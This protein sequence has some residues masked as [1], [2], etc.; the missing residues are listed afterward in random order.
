MSL[1]VEHREVI[2]EAAH[3]MLLERAA[4][5]TLDT[6]DPLTQLSE[7]DAV[8]CDPECSW[9]LANSLLKVSESWEAAMSTSP[10]D[11]AQLRL[12]HSVSLLIYDQTRLRRLRD[13]RDHSSF[14]V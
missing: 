9:L 14:G 1:E 12:V 5:G 7:V 13:A 6:D 2:V 4:R 3:R 8:W 11:R 10:R